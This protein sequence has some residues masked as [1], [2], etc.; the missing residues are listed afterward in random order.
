MKLQS[1]AC[2]VALASGGLFLTHVVNVATASSAT[3]VLTPSREQSLVARQLA[4]LMDRQHYLNM[5][6]DE[7]TSRR[8]LD[9]YIDTLDPEHSLF[10]QQD[11]S[12][13][14]QK[15]ADQLGR[16]LKEGDLSPAFEIYQRYLTRMQAYQTFVLTQLEQPQSLNGTGTVEVDREKAPFFATDAQQQ[17]YWHQQLIS[18]LISL[19]V[20]KEEEAAKQKALQADPSLAS[21]QDLSSSALGP[22]DTL[23]KRYRRQVEQLGRVKNDQ[24]LESVLNAALA[25]YDP[26]SNYFAPVEAMEMNRQTTLALE[27]IGV[28]IRPER[29][30]EDYTRIES[31]VD[32]GP[33]SKSGQVRAGDRI[34]GVAQDGGPL[35]DVVGWPS[36]EIVGLIRGKRGTKVTVRLQASSPANAPSRQVLLVRDVIEQDDAGLQHRVIEV[37]SGD[38]V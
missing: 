27:G 12:E 31:I 4:T 7:A 23:K 14:K 21:G 32:G 1:L 15:Y 38:Q 2:A 5:P 6:L 8:V 35:V 22:V 11:V 33:A 36:N 19:T 13:F 3:S 18:Q 26:H 29:G 25:T 16:L 34:T 24:V 17:Q 10:L 28:S 37:K 9:M 30:N 20:G